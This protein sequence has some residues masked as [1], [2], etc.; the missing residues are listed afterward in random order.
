VAERPDDELTRAVIGL[1]GIVL[2]EGT[3]DTV[4]ELVSSLARSSIQD[5]HGVSV[6]LRQAERVETRYATGELVAALDGVQYRE[7]QGPCMTAMEVG[8]PQNVS[9]AEMETRW[10]RFA[11]AAGDA[12][13][14]RVLSV[15]L[16]VQGRP[17]GA[18]NLYAREGDG[19]GPADESRARLFA[20]HASVVLANAAAFATAEARASQ[21]LEALESRDVIGQAKGIIMARE[22]CDA[23]EAFD[24]LRRASQRT[25]KK[26]RDL[27]QEVVDSV[28]QQRDSRE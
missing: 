12:G 18:M 19:F 24:V 4:L 11:A 20:H 21:L 16:H 26:L 23:E 5:V 14:G 15:P 9:L 22:G 1:A 10:P 13:I 28:R 17:I 6:T 2:G 27:A 25:H 7:R 3:L 8:R